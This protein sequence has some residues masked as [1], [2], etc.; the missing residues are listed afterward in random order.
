MQSLGINTQEVFYALYSSSVEIMDGEYKTGEKQTTYHAP[1]S[2]WAN[3][4]PQRG[5]ADYEPFG[6]DID[7]DRTMVLSDMNCPIDEHSVLWLGCAPSAPHNYIVQ[8][9]AK[10]LNSITY[11]LKEVKVKANENTYGNA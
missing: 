6:V 1:V 2:M 5:T 7:Y 11:A 4:S 10:S 8:R 3:V 9:V